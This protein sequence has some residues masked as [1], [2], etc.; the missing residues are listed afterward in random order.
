MN[1]YHTSVLLQEV[2][3]FLAIAV[4]ERY[5]DAT[6]GGGG[7]TLEIVKRGGNVLGIDTDSD[8]IEEVHKKYSA[9][10]LS[11][12]QGTL[13]TVQGNFESIASIAKEE[14]FQPVAGVLFDLGVSSHQLDIAERGFSF[15]E[16]PLDMR[17]NTT[18]AVKAADLV[19][20]LTRGELAEL[21][22]R[23]GEEKFAKRIANAIASKRVAEPFTTTTQ[24]VQVISSSVPFIEGQIHP[25]TRV[26]QALRI[27]VNDEMNV[28][29]RALPD[30]FTLLQSGGRLVV[31]S[32]HSLE[33]RIVK[34]TFEKLAEDGVGEIV[35]K[36]PITP[37]EQEILQ[38]KRSR[39][40]KL[41]VIQK[42]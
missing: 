21:F 3:D 30:A 2:I 32:F 27:A 19:N 20:G 16:G 8:A 34:Q 11:S 13:Q 38:N 9:L 29:R 39:S 24:L 1:N 25:A 23:Y 41:R 22:E 5:I 6:L 37:S 31:I 35:T 28:L 7:H 10:S 12:D 18:L 40:S 15:K 4:G 17:M 14:S 36:K 33:D 42:I 26:F